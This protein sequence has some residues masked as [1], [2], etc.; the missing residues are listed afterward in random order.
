MRYSR[1]SGQTLV[2]LLVFMMIMIAL[3][4]TATTLAVVSSS[5]TLALQEGTLARE[6]AATGIENAQVQL[7]RNTNYTGEVLNLNGGVV[8]IEVTGDNPKTITA[9]AQAGNFVRSVQA[10]AQYTNGVL[11]ITSWQEL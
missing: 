11:T 7:V 5:S 1:Q 6:L 3:A 4:T 9:T 8:T 10:M 2:L